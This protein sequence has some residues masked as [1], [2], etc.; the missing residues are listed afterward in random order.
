MPDDLKEVVEENKIEIIEQKVE[1]KKEITTE[2]LVDF[3]DAEKEMAQKQGILKNE[4]TKKDSVSDK[5]VLDEKKSVEEKTD[6]TF[7]DT[8]KN[9]KDLIKNYSK[10]EQALYWKWKHDKKLRQDSLFQVFITS[11]SA[12]FS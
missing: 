11:Q 1:E 8:E 3:S 9:E 6:Q 10:N 5:K 4:D 2:D 7:E 12:I